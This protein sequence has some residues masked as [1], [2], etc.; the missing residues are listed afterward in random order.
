MLGDLLPA[1]TFCLPGKQEIFDI[2]P[3]SL[4]KGDPDK[5]ANRTGPKLA[6][7]GEL[8]WWRW[9]DRTFQKEAILH[10]AGIG[11][12]PPPPLSAP[13]WVLTLTPA[14]GVQVTTWS[15]S[16]F[17]QCES[18]LL[19]NVKVFSRTYLFVFVSCFFFFFF[20]NIALKF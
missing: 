13:S 16:V 20:L 17:F 12:L 19:S 18:L 4:D 11:A 9:E 10:T 1:F 14:F 15:L 6:L 3:Y 5:G 8:D 7:C 2:G